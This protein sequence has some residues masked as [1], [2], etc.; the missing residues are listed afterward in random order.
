MEPTRWNRCPSAKY[1]LALILLLA[2]PILSVPANAQ[3]VLTYHGDNLRTGWFS[4]GN[5]VDD[6]QLN[7]NRSAC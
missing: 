6:Q 1:F 3:N 4:P 2:M 7:G 5:A